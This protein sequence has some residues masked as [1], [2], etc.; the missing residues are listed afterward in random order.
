MIGERCWA[1]CGP[2]GDQLPGGGDVA[3]AVDGERRAHNAV[4]EVEGDE[5]AALDVAADDHLVTAAAVSR[6]LQVLAELI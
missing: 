3:A 1:G 5:V 4:L 6:I 2:G